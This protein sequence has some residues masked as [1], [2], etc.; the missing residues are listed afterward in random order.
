MNWCI[1]HVRYVLRARWVVACFAA[2]FLVTMLGSC[3]GPYS[4]EDAYSALPSTN[5]P[6]VTRHR[7]NW[8]PAAVGY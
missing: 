4:T 6:A 5:N 2:C 3:G 7:A 8:Q 1:E